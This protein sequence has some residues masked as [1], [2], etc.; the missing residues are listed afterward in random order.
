VITVTR[1]WPYI[2]VATL[3]CLLAAATSA[4]AECAWVLWTK[5]C[6][7]LGFDFCIRDAY[8]TK[9]ECRTAADSYIRNLIN[10]ANTERAKK[11]GGFVE[12]PEQT[13]RAVKS[14]VATGNIRCLPDTV[15]PRGPKGK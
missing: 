7:Q 11:E 15:D 8:I 4:S 9:D 14:M 12:N 5:G 2:V 1:R 3:C 10:A 6:G 13:E